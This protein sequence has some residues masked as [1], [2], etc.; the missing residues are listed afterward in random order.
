MADS[1]C[2]LL[3]DCDY[4]WDWGFFHYTW[5][6]LDWWEQIQVWRVPLCSFRSRGAMWSRASSPWS[7]YTE[8]RGL[9][10]L[11]EWICTSTRVWR[12]QWSLSI[13]ME[14]L[15]DLLR[16]CLTSYA[17][18]SRWGGIHWGCAHILALFKEIFGSFRDIF[19]GE[20]IIPS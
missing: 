9:V 2:F 16:S 15:W 14:G 6:L 7:R 18:L 12:M 20:E 10:A 19:S 11:G 3:Q 5:E 13:S 1:S 17:L 4:L 8:D